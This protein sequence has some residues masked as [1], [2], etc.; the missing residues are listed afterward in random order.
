MRLNL[1]ECRHRLVGLA[2]GAC[3]LV[4]ACWFAPQ[5][6]SG[7]AAAPKTP[8][9]SSGAK[10]PAPAVKAP[11]TAPKAS[12]GGTKPAALATTPQRTPEEEQARKDI[13]ESGSWQDVMRQFSEWLSIQVLYDDEQVRHIRSRLQT[14]I[15]RMSAE[16]LQRFEGDLREKL[17]VL[18]SEQAVEAQNYLAAKFLVASE[19]YARRI[20]QQL[21]DVLSMTPAQI[22]QRLAVY[23]TKRQSRA[24]VQQSFEQ[25]REPPAGRQCLPSAGPPAAASR[26]CCV[27][28]LGSGEIRHAE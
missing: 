3:C 4:A 16:Q 27:A 10:P 5:R 26:T 2:A 19:A 28:R 24:Q 15:G 8:G 17:G 22:E 9:K 12:S 21:P 6:V 20:R 1:S 18:T 25:S 11:A 14:G 13:L 7:Q 23:A